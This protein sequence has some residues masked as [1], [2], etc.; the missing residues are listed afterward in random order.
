MK[1]VVTRVF[2]DKGYAFLRDSDGLT[3]FFNANDMARVS[4][5]DTL[6]EGLPIDFEPQGT[7]N[8]SFE[9][10]HNGLSAIDL[11]VQHG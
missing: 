3:R 8:K 6:Y 2:L 1:G 9:A 7:L 5:W 10:K 11:V 4:D